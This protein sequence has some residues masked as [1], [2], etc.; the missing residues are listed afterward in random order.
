MAV[1][2]SCNLFSL[3]IDSTHGEVF[4]YDDLSYTSPNQLNSKDL[5]EV[6]SEENFH[7]NLF[8]PMLPRQ[9]SELRRKDDEKL[10]SNNLLRY[11]LVDR[12]AS[13]GNIW[14]GY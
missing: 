7:L 14:R 2:G 4:N 10:T 1:S 6:S 8:S 3:F 13:L 11:S 9:R 12:T 5:Y